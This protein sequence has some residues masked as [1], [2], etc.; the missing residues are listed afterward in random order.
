MPLSGKTIEFLMENRL[1]NS[2]AW[3]EEHRMEYQNVVLEPL[4]E[5]SGRLGPAMLKIDDQ[6][7]TEP[8][9]GKTISRIRR[10]T[11]FSKDKSL[12]REN[13]W[14]IFKRGAM[15]GTEVPGLYFEFS[16][17]GFEYGVG[18]YAASPSYMETLRKAVIENTEEFRLAQKVLQSYHAFQVTGDV[19]KRPHYLD[20]PQTLRNWL[21]RRNICITAESVDFDLLFS[22]HLAP[23]LEQEFQKAS[24]IYRFLLYV[25]QRKRAEESSVPSA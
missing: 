22:D 3:F 9:V 15:Y 7:T 25:A 8:A 24:P 14:I 21:E 11:R 18:F 10:D 13:L 17:N 1:C 23:F 12:Y 20:K 19:Y 6:L 2:K 4:K 5:L 16:P